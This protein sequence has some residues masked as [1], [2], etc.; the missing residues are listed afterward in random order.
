MLDNAFPFS[1]QSW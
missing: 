1:E